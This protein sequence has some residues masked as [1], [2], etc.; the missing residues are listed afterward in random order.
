MKYFN[1]I[2][3][4]FSLQMLDTDITSVINV[5]PVNP[6]DIPEDVISCIGHP[7]TAAVISSELNRNIPVNRINVH[8]IPGDT[9][10]VAQLIGGRLPAGATKLPEEFDIKY[11]KVSVI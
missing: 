6:E 3:N 9:L 10:Y 8:L 2:S 1:Y 4:A 7:D 5:T 11:L